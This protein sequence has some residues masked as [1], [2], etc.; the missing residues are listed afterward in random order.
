MYIT[1]LKF[2][3]AFLDFQAAST[4]QGL[5]VKCTNYIVGCSTLVE[6][7]KCHSHASLETLSRGNQLIF[8]CVVSPLVMSSKLTSSR[9]ASV[10][11]TYLTRSSTFLGSVSSSAKKNR[12]QRALA[13][14]TSSTRVP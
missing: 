7:Q 9:C 6:N 10:F 2:H 14:A 11:L 12:F 5:I 13:K 4:L 1:Q 3:L 8:S